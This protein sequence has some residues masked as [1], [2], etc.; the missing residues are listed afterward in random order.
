MNV[1]EW[2]LFTWYDLRRW[3]C[4]I[5]QVITAHVITRV[6]TGHT[7]Q[8]Q[9][10]QYHGA[11]HSHLHWSLEKSHSG[12]S[13]PVSIIFLVCLSSHLF[14]ARWYN[15]SAPLIHL[16]ARA[17]HVSSARVSELNWCQSWCLCQ[18]S[19]TLT[20]CHTRLTSHQGDK[21]QIMLHN[22]GITLGLWPLLAITHTRV[23][24]LYGHRKEDT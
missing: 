10:Q 21:R 14:L 15:F 1:F 17:G 7:G 8:K 19:V 12:L 22:Y 3:K 16:G 6:I 20:A 5:H 18:L 24:K 2:I 13:H 23:R 4:C 11:G 9:S